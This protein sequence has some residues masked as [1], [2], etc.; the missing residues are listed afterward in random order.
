MKTTYLLIE[1]VTEYFRGVAFNSIEDLFGVSDD[2]DV[3]K[4]VALEEN[5]DKGITWYPTLSG[6]WEA[7]I[8][9]TKKYEI[10]STNVYSKL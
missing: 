2:V 10:I 9:D 7:K 4:E 3:L 6:N 8:S 1:T 5:D